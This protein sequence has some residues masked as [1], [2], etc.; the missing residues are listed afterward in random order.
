LVSNSEVRIHLVVPLDTGEGDFDILVSV[1]SH[2]LEIG[3]DGVE[4]ANAI[5]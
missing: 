2:C 5:E 3:V 4:C 1:A